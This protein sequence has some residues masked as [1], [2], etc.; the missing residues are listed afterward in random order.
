[1][2]TTGLRSKEVT[3]CTNSGVLSIFLNWPAVRAGA[4]ETMQVP[5]LRRRQ[6][7]EYCACWVIM[8]SAQL[9]DQRPVSFGWSIM[10]LDG[11]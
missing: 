5:V 7:R 6:V 1:M 3:M 9:V 10:D 11:M 4:V 2:C 8:C